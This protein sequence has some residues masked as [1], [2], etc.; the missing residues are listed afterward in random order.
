LDSSVRWVIDEKGAYV[1]LQGFKG[2]PQPPPDGEM[3]EMPLLRLVVKDGKCTYSKSSQMSRLSGFP[4]DYLKLMIS[5][6]EIEKTQATLESFGKYLERTQD[7]AEDEE[8]DSDRIEDGT[9]VLVMVG[10]DPESGMPVGVGGRR[11]SESLSESSLMTLI[12]AYEEMRTD[13]L[14]CLI[15]NCLM[16]GAVNVVDYN[17]EEE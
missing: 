4:P 16:N 7:G 12:G 11:I 14:L 2:A 15:V 1:R 17:D 9:Y 3:E 5:A 13:V 10:L 6:M 8:A